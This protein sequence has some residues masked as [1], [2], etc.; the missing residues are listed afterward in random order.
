[1]TKLVYHGSKEYFDIAIPKRQRRSKFD[2]DRN[3]VT[4]FDEISFHATPHRWIALAY[5]CDQKRYEIDGKIAHY[6]MGV[7][8]YEHRKELEILGFESLE[9]SL[10]ALFGDGGWLMSFDKNKFCHMEG[11][12]NLE[13]ICQSE[14]KPEKIERIDDPVAEL[15][16]EGV[17]FRFTDLA[18]PKNAH[19]RNYLTN[20]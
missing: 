18:K 15:E 9:K 1:M 12:G 16:K 5:I 4:I 11:L 6:I 3:L 10:E 7:D 19:L 20:N 17:T 2:S 14:I 13:V 8:L